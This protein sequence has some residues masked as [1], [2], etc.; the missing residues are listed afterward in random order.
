MQHHTPRPSTWCFTLSAQTTA[1]CLQHYLCCWLTFI[2]TMQGSSYSVPSLVCVTTGGTCTHINR[3]WTGFT[4]QFTDRVD[5][6]WALRAARYI[7]KMQQPCG[8]CS[9]TCNLAPTA[10]LLETTESFEG[11]ARHDLIIQMSRR[12]NP[13][14]FG[15]P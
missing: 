7:N 6:W 8:A 5:A 11:T 13:R 3:L 10:N 2:Y 1:I 9:T 12:K 14:G 15:T 4:A